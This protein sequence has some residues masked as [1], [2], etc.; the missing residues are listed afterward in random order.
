MS[1]YSHMISDNTKQMFVDIPLTVT[2]QCLESLHKLG[3]ADSIFNE[4]MN[5]NVF[6]SSLG[7]F[8]PK[9][10]IPAVVHGKAPI[11]PNKSE[12][13]CVCLY[14][15]IVNFVRIDKQ[16]MFQF[17]MQKW[18]LFHEQQNESSALD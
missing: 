15:K 7:I 1:N 9:R 16:R 17:C 4:N 13:F 5:E 10:W 12:K 2:Q 18:K 6:K 3:L 11:F 8:D 14:Q